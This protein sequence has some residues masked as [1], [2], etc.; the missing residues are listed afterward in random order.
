ML[1]RP[2]EPGGA[3]LDLG[4]VSLPGARPRAHI[5]RPADAKL[6]PGLEPPRGPALDGARNCGSR[7]LLQG[8]KVIGRRFGRQFGLRIGIR[9]AKGRYGGH[10]VG[11]R[12]GETGHGRFPWWPADNVSSCDWMRGV[13]QAWTMGPAPP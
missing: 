4:T 5:A 2:R 3:G 8:V 13:G 9:L 1:R 10:R 7:R 11:W 6:R 12:D